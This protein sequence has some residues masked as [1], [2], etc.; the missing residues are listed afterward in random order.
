MAEIIHKPYYWKPKEPILIYDHPLSKAPEGYMPATLL[1]FIMSSSCDRPDAYNI[2]SAMV[3]EIV[4]NKMEYMGDAII[5]LRVGDHD[6]TIN[7]DFETDCDEPY[8]YCAYTD[9]W[10]GEEKIWIKYIIL[11]DGVDDLMEGVDSND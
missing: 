11:V 10:E 1:D 2:V 3:Y 6:V 8:Y 9:W 4:C 5:G 7:G